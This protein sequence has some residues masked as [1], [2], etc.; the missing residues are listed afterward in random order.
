MIHVN[1]MSLQTCAPSDDSDQT[2]Q[3]TRSLIRIFT[4]RILESQACK[5]SSDSDDSEQTVPITL[6]RLCRS[7]VDLS[8]LGA[9]VRRHFFS[10]CGS[11]DNV[12]CKPHVAEGLREQALWYSKRQTKS[13]IQTKSVFAVRRILN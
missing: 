3:H 6:G 13:E 8:S 10:L 12:T 7:Q 4:G 5:V 2:T 11:N 1:Q 9:L